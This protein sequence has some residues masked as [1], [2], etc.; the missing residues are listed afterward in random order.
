MSVVWHWHGRCRLY[1]GSRGVH[2]LFGLGTRIHKGVQAGLEN[3]DTSKHCELFG[4]VYA[5]PFGHSYSCHFARHT[6]TDDLGFF[7]F[8]NIDPEAEAL[9]WHEPG[10]V[11]RA[12]LMADGW[13]LVAAGCLWP[14]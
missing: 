6:Y 11:V 9:T 1:A 12:W 5:A 2:G 4:R 3:V 8:I 13:W 7:H 10:V 14:F